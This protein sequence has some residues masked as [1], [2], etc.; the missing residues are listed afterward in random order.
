MRSSS[1][2][3]HSFS[4]SNQLMVSA[5]SKRACGI[6][7]EH[8]RPRSVSL[9]KYILSN[10]ERAV[11]LQFTSDEQEAILRA[12][13]VKEACF[14]VRNEGRNPSDYQITAL[15]NESMCTVKTKRS[16]YQVFT[17]RFQQDYTLSVAILHPDTKVVL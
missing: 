16:T 12:W 6:D 14:K 4:H 17:S 8:H 1:Y 3:H 7:I 11:F 15:D 9:L 5:A 13:T 10:S 2:S